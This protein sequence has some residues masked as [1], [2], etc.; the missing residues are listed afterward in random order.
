MSRGLS[1]EEAQAL[2][3]GIALVVVTVG[4]IILKIKI[5]IIH[6][7]QNIFW[8]SLCVAPLFL[9][10]C[11]IFLFLGIFK[12]NGNDYYWESEFFTK[13]MLF[14]F[15]IVLFILSILS[16][17][18]MA[19]SYERGYS[20][21]ALEKLAEYEKQLESLQ[22][23]QDILTG[24]IIWEVQNQA[25]EDIINTSCKNPNYSCNQVRQ[26][27]EIYKSIKGAKDSADNVAAFFGF[28]D[29]THQKLSR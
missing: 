14:V 7:F 10:A 28:I 16:L 11:I 5:G 12:Q 25:V 18:F 2:T 24:Q 29:K 23:I 8:V 13:G 3:V 6:F 21:E 26:N 4:I 20:N 19:Y 1:K 15:S 22:Q 27:F 17:W 9:L